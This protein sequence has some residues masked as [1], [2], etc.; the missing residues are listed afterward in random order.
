[1]RYRILSTRRVLFL[2]SFA[3]ILVSA[4]GRLNGQESQSFPVPSTGS[5]SASSCEFTENR[6]QWPDSIL[7]RASTDEATL[8]FTKDGIYYQFFEVL[9]RGE[10]QSKENSPESSD[11]HRFL[12]KTDLV[13]VRFVGANDHA[14]AQGVGLL[15]TNKNYF[16]G[17]EPTRWQ[18]NVP[19][20]ES[21]KIR[22]LYPGVDIIFSRRE[23]RL[24]YSLYGSDGAV[25]KAMVA[26]DGSIT[27]RS[28]EVIT[29][30]TKVGRRTFIGVLPISVDSTR[31]EALSSATGIASANLSVIYSR[32][33]GGSD[34]DRGEA[35]AVDASGCAYVTGTTFSSNFPLV[36]PV[37]GNAS[38]SE[39]FVA[40]YSAD[41]TDTIYCTY[42]GGSGGE[43]SFGGIAVDADGRAYI[44]GVTSST[45]Y[46]T[47][48]GALQADPGDNNYDALTTKLSEFGNALVYSTYLGGDN[49]DVGLDIVVDQSG[50][51]FVTG[52]TKSSNFP[53]ANAFQSSLGS[54]ANYDAFVT[55]LSADGGSM[56]FS[57]YLGGNGTDYG[58]GIAIGTAGNP[59]IAG[60]TTSDNFPTKNA[61]Q[62]TAGGSDGFVTKMGVGGDSLIYS[63]YLRG[64]TGAVDQ[65]QGIA[66]DSAG[67]AFVTGHT[68][69]ATFPTMSAF[70]GTYGGGTHDAFVTKFAPSGTSL[71]YSTFM[72]GS[73]ADSALDI[74]VDRFGSAYVS[75]TT[76]SDNFPILSQYQSD[77]A[78]GDMFVARLSRSGGTLVYSTYL[79]GNGSDENRGIAIS[80]SGYCYIT[81][82][83]T[84]NQFPSGSGTT[85]F[86][87]SVVTVKLSRLCCT[88]TTGDLNI[89][90]FIDLSDQSLLI[91][92][93]TTSP[94]PVLPCPEEANVSG[95]GGI[96]LTDLSMLIA[97]LTMTPRPTLPNCP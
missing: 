82:F 39:L 42:L 41:A 92:Y 32:Y 62:P 8:W 85:G 20:Y 27:Q 48:V 54:V 31:C 97:Y 81:G 13:K 49:D 78:T 3:L 18:T 35:I 89:D 61:Y 21:L 47:T 30:D 26:I 58:H 16:I 7:F 95:T 69:D 10:A 77:S 28:D 94:K 66:V 72:G 52:R 23:G 37:D 55:K 11:N 2:L 43:E 24:E 33:L 53:T 59:Y 22:E 74:A 44:T 86:P 71:I 17:N 5:T 87:N 93:V 65:I 51:A 67:A 75:G 64:S 50:C 73:L 80:D 63:T 68:S 84:S 36:N 12:V 19:S 76:S 15:S 1:M 46:P 6:G 29:I 4:A 34:V 79:R 56:I 40:K 38:G 45:N 14:Q 25:S 57:T 60:W 90:G 96:D 91:A 70:Q 88:G 83:T 9:S